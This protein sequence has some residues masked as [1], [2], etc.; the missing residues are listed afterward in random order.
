MT[1]AHHA[2]RTSLPHLKKPGGKS[3]RPP[4]LPGSLS[5]PKLASKAGRSK[6][7]EEPGAPEE[8]DKEM[9]TSFLQYCAMCEKQIVV[10]NNSILYCSESCRRKD[11]CKYSTADSYLGAYSTSKASIVDPMHLSDVTTRSIV[12]RRKP[13]VLPDDRSIPPVLH[14]FKS[15]LDPTEWKPDLKH[16]PSS[17]ANRY[18][19][20]FHRS[21]PSLSATRRPDLHERIATAPVMIAPSLSHTPTASMSSSEGSIAGTPYEF[22]ADIE[23]PEGGNAV[24]SVP[25]SPETVSTAKAT[26]VDKDAP[27]PIVETK[28]TKRSRTASHIIGDI[29]YE[30]KWV[31]SS[32]EH[33]QGSLKKLLYLQEMAEVAETVE[34]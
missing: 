16:R 19:S 6:V 15:D 7:V 14:H 28:P 2:H 32:V 30:K 1:S 3:H 29:V 20:Q 13:T 18:L 27:S 24:C 21:T 22:V 33:V 10:P 17:E 11:A 23:A 34:I 8:E 25:V 4:L 9:A 31:P 5:S 26:F 12:P